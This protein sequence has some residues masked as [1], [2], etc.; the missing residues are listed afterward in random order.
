MPMQKIK[1]AQDEW[2]MVFTWASHRAAALGEMWEWILG[3]TVP[4][5]TK[6]SE[7]RTFCHNSVVMELEPVSQGPKLKGG[8]E[9]VLE[10]PLMPIGGGLPVLCQ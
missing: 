6:V 3:Q 10:L 5:K 2:S 8:S 9:L 4:P 1:D 7:H